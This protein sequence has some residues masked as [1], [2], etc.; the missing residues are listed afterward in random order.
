MLSRVVLGCGEDAGQEFPLADDFEEVAC[1]HWGVA[2]GVPP[3]RDEG[4][5]FLCLGVG[6]AIQLFSVGEEGR[7]ACRR[8]YAADYTAP[9]FEGTERAPVPGG[10][11]LGDPVL[12]L[13]LIHI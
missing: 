13:S 2:V 1:L 7:Y 11:A 5:P 9:G 6:A 8:Q 3:C 10:P 12:N 4:A